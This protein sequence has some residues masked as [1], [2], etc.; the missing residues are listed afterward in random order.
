MQTAGL[1][2]INS[3]LLMKLD[4]EYSPLQVRIQKFYEELRQVLK[5]KEHEQM[6][7]LKEM[8]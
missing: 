8:K 6:I 1:I 2:N 5:R 7:I 3:E 4:R